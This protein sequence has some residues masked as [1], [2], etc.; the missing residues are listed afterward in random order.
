VFFAKKIHIGLDIGHFSVKAAVLGP[1]KRDILDLREVEITPARALLE[2]KPTD[3]QVTEAIRKATAEYTD[4][5]SGYNPSIACAIQGEGAICRYVEIP[6][7]DRNRQEMAI[8]SAVLKSIS[9]PLED[10]ILSHVSVPV[11]GRAEGSGIFFFAIK[12]SATAK[13][14]ELTAKSGVKV[15]RFELPAVALIKGFTQNREIPAD[16]FNAIVHIGSILTLIIIMRRGNPYYM[17]EFAT[18]GR[19]FT[20]AFQMGA[21]STW[22]EAEEYKHSYDATRMEVPFEPVLARWIDQVRKTLAAFSRLD[23]SSSSAVSGIYLTGGSSSLKG[24]DR[25]LSEA[26]DIPVNVEAWDRLKA[27]GN[28]DGKPFGTFTVATGMVI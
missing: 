5:G 22:K 18:A 3:E 7:L 12:K 25:R 8:Q 11:L 6:K 1:N 2:E 26:L 23:S 27:E 21:Q 16:Q 14:Q 4:K 10:A 9:F 20:Y 28:L 24:L 13:L 17:R 19:D 15:E